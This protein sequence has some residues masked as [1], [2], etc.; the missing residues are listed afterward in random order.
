MTPEDY[1]W[2]LENRTLLYNSIRMTTEQGHKCF[3]LYNKI[4][5]TPMNYT[6]C[7]SCVRTVVGLLRQEFEKHTQT[8]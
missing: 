1:S 8:I 3:E 5:P 4:A 2:L 6:T 7:G